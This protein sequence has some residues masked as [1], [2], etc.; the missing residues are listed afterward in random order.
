MM[1]RTI[2]KFLEDNLSHYSTQSTR[3]VILFKFHCVLYQN[4]KTQLF[5]KNIIYEVNYYSVTASFSDAA[6]SW[7]KH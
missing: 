1:Y 4:K 5:H 3:K 6:D 2:Q 7:L